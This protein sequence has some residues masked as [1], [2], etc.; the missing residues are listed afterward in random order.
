MASPFHQ[1]YLPPAM[2]PYGAPATL[3]APVLPPT[4]KRETSP[5]EPVLPTIPPAAEPILPSPDAPSPSAIDGA[6]SA[7]SKK[8][9]ARAG[10]G[11]GAGGGGASTYKNKPLMWVPPPTYPYN[12]I[13]GRDLY[14]DVIPPRPTEAEQCEGSGWYKVPFTEDASEPGP[15]GEVKKKKKPSGKKKGPKGEGGEE[16]GCED[17]EGLAG[18]GTLSLGAANVHDPEGK[19]KSGLSAVANAEASSGTVKKKKP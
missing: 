2:N 19:P 11:V 18:A 6:A 1:P 14:A 17:E 3:A 4:I 13:P 8:K 5:F 9:V 10:H 7:S 16:D 12:L 15:S